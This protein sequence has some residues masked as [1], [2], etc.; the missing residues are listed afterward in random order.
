ME[1]E[2]NGPCEKIDQIS[3]CLNEEKKRTKR[4]LK[5]TLSLEKNCL[6]FKV[7]RS[8]C[9]YINVPQKINYFAYLMQPVIS[10]WAW[11]VRILASKHF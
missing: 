8:K 7:H 3:P 11:R 6:C 4:A 5:L 2:L 9:Y 1:I 10:S